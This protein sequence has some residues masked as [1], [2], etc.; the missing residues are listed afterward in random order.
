VST[1]TTQKLNSVYF[2]NNNIG[3]IAG[4]FGTILKTSDGGNTWTVLSSGITQDLRSIYFTDV[5]TGYI[6]GAFHTILKLLMAAQLGFLYQVQP[7][8]G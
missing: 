3:Y 5:N 7:K 6:V 8:T 1:S 4:N 2:V